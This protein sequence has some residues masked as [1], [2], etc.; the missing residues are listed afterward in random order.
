VKT[1]TKII[2]TSSTPNY[3][4]FSEGINDEVAAVLPALTSTK[5]RKAIP[6]VTIVEMTTRA[7]HS[8]P[9]N[10]IQFEQKFY[11]NTPNSFDKILEQQYKIKGIDPDSDENYEEDER[12]IGV[13][14]SQVICRKFRL[15]R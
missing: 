3:E 7:L 9:P 15:T 8:S 14:G 1:S 6:P 13:L 10:Q 5:P 12:L 2:E 4:H 11:P